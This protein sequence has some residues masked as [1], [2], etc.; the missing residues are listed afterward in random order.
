MAYESEP[1]EEEKKEEKPKKK[2]KAKS[3]TVMCRV[4]QPAHITDAFIGYYS[5]VA[6]CHL[7]PGSTVGIT[8]E[9]FEELEEFL[10]ELPEKE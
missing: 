9:A 2:A 4:L 7:Q 10:E 6:K 3:A 5:Q 8:R 1:L